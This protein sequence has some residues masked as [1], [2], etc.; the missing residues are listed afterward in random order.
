MKHLL[1]F[2][3]T[4]STGLAGW[5]D[6]SAQERADVRAELASYGW[7]Q[8]NA[9]LRDKINLRPKT[10]VSKVTN[11]YSRSMFEYEAEIIAKSVAQGASIN[12]NDTQTQK[13]TKLKNWIAAGSDATEKLE[14]AYQGGAFWGAWFAIKTLAGTGNT[15]LQRITDVQNYGQS[16]LEVI[17]V[18]TKA[19]NRD[20]ESARP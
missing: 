7:N 9:A 3:L 5:N 12:K 2:L 8:P 14:R 17:G 19:T 20:I 4:A 16:P 13:N 11:T 6:W 10:T 18:T 1:I 15:T